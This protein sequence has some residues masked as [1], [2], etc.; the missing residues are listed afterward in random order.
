MTAIKSIYIYI[1][2]IK[3]LFMIS[4]RE[5]VFSTSFYNKFLD[6]KIPSRFFF[7]PNPYLLSPL[8][9]HK[10]LIIKISNEDVKNLWIN[11]LKNK[12]KKIYIIFYG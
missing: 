6:S 3:K 12:E 2:S 11:I 7:Y 5:F 4:I 10:D 1:L 9:N 8:L